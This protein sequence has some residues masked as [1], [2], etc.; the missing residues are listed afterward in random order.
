MT[1]PYQS[2]SLNHPEQGCTREYKLRNNE[3]GIDLGMA[4]ISENTMKYK[5]RDLPRRMNGRRWCY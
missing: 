2:Y 5:K 1:C 3:V 4:P